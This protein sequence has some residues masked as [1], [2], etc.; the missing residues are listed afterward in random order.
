[1]VRLA[2]PSDFETFEYLYNSSDIDI[3]FNNSAEDF[4]AIDISDVS[5]DLD[6]D[7]IS[8][9]IS[10]FEVSH[11]IFLNILKSKTERIF[12]VEKDN[13]II[14]FAWIILIKKCRWKLY[15]L[16]ILPEYQSESIIT[17]ILQC[18]LLQKRVKELDIC[19][20]SSSLKFLLESLGATK[21]LNLYYR[22]KQPE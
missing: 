4:K 9:F 8:K 14:G 15:A 2:N 12:M 3:L 10:E 6:I 5:L 16:N 7:L 18:L 20:L 19:F 22:I 11:Q 1:M 21:I 17:K 13:Q